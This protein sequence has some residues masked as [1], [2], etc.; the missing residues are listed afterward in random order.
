MATNPMA[1]A[2]ANPPTNQPA[3]N[4]QPQTT[5]FALTPSETIQ[6]IIDYS[7]KFVELNIYYPVLLFQSE[8]LVV[9][10]ILKNKINANVSLIIFLYWSVD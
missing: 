7:T 4:P 1:Q 8:W 9:I 10:K 6:E 3:V 5:M 2:A